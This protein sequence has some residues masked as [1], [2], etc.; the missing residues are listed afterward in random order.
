M[1][2]TVAELGGRIAMSAVLAAVL[3]LAPHGPAFAFLDSINPFADTKDEFEGKFIDSIEPGAWVPP[4]ERLAREHQA[5]SGGQSAGA[6]SGRMGEDDDSAAVPAK[7]PEPAEI[8]IPDGLAFLRI[9]QNWVADSPVMERYLNGIGARLLATSPVTGA[10]VR[11]YVTASEDFGLAEALPDGAVG[12]PMAILQNVGTEDELAYILAHEAAH[13]LLEHHDND[14]FQKLNQNFVAAAELAVGTAAALAQQFGDNRLAQ[15]ALAVSLIGEGLLFVTDKGLFPSFTRE[16]EDEADLLGFD[17]TVA[18]GYNSQA[19]FDAMEKLQSWQESAAVLKAKKADTQKAQIEQE[20]GSAANRG[21]FATAFSGMVKRL[22]FA[23]DEATDEISEGHRDAESRT[24]SLSDYYFREHADDDAAPLMRNVELLRA[25]KSSEVANI[26]AGYGHAR[27]ALALL[28]DGKLSEAQ[29][30]AGQAV[31]GRMKHDSLARYAFFKT[32]LTQGKKAKAIANLELA[33]KGP[34]PAFAIYRQLSNLYWESGRRAE[35]VK[36]LESAFEEF[37]KP[38]P[39]YPDIIYRAFS[40]GDTR[41]ANMMSL[42]CGVKHRDMRD[43]CQKA[44]QGLAIDTA[45]Q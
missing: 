22:G 20:M 18:A 5:R 12:I 25:L 16:Q 17:L 33:L 39:L 32:R 9:T 4:L 29:K 14:W 43:L 8:K 13:V 21:D 23:A 44:A 36:V 1:R 15:A 45:Q 19:A 6:A 35:S 10:P 26:V 28:S 30:A 7:P 11:Y 2:G 31:S 34:R 3:T 41:K 42:E 38:P 24:E 40:L 37:D 27:Q